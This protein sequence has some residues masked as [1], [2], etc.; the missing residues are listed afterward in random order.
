[1]MQVMTTD[2]PCECV[3]GVIFATTR[4]LRIK[5]AIGNFFQLSSLFSNLPLYFQLNSRSPSANSRRN[6]AR[7]DHQSTFLRIT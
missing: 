4:C 5:R 6:L 7:F 1:M 3:F 2:P